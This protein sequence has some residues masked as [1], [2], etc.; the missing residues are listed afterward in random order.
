MYLNHFI[1]DSK[2][3]TNILWLSTEKNQ[4][5]IFIFVEIEAEIL[6]LPP[7]SLFTV[8]RSGGSKRT[9]MIKNTL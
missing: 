4:T 1:F 2:S 7:K 6:P 3:K 5:S 9:V 8:R